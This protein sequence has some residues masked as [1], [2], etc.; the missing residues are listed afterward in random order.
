MRCL[1]R[2]SKIGPPR[3]VVGKK[4]TK[5]DVCCFKSAFPLVVPE[6]H[7]RA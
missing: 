3:S 7:I 1:V 5:F 6:N 2:H 4:L